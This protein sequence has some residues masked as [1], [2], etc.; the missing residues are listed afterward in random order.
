[1]VDPITL[2]VSSVG[3]AAG[4]ALASE[5]SRLLRELIGLQEAQLQMLQ[6]I[7]M[8][9]DA[10]IT[11]PFNAGTRLL[12]SALAEGRDG[13]DRQGLL[14]E[15]RSAFVLALS[16]DPEPLR[17]SLAALHLAAVWLALG[18]PQDVRKSLEEAHVLALRAVLVEQNR[19]VSGLRGLRL[20]FDENARRSR[21]ENAEAKIVPY[22][23]ELARARRSWGSTGVQAPIFVG[24]FTVGGE[25]E[26]LQVVLALRVSFDRM[27]ELRR[28][29]LPLPGDGAPT[30][31]SSEMPEWVTDRRLYDTVHA[32]VMLGE[33]L[34]VT[35]LEEWLGRAAG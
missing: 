19:S 35:A 33:I 24:P 1:M 8:K 3:S 27:Q 10:L 26:Q 14:R 34:P 16:Q 32:Q 7:D 23:N 21:L 9:V 25:E 4:K 6:Q 12:I 20:R 13:S 29:I 11:G 22:A 30:A 18:S 28:Q 31:A 15:A 2:F 5:G 17:Q